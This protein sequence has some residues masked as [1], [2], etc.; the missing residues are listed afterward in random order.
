MTDIIDIGTELSRNLAKA[1]F[2][3]KSNRRTL[4]QMTADFLGT[5]VPTAHVVMGAVL[6]G[7]LSLRKSD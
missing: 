5:D 7:A 1:L 2:P 6:L 3:N 4:S